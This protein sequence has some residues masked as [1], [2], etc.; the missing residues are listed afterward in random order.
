MFWF[1]V[2]STYLSA[3]FMFIAAQ[4]GCSSMRT[5]SC[6][7]CQRALHDNVS[8]VHV[9]Y[10]S[11]FHF[12][13]CN[14]CPLVSMFIAAIFV[15]INAHTYILCSGLQCFLLTCPLVSMFIAAQSLCSST[16][17]HILNFLVYSA[18]YFHVRL[19]QC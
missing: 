5:C 9:H 3:C 17:T 19:F 1:T 10:H 11:A 13:T 12:D 14:T 15:L 7:Y 8:M 4:P 6:L 18:F 16:R 2:L